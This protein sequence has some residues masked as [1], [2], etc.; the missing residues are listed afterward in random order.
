VYMALTQAGE[1]P[2]MGAFIQSND[3]RTTEHTPLTYTFSRDAQTGV[4][5]IRYSEPSGFPVKFHWDATIT[6]DGTVVTTQMVVEQ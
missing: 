6:L 5:T 3:I 1:G 4:V 2:V